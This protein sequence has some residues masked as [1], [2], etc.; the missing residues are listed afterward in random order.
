MTDQET[1]AVY[2]GLVHNDIDLISQFPLVW[3][4]S[5]CLGPGR[6]GGVAYKLRGL[7]LLDFTVHGSGV[8]SVHGSGVLL[9]FE[10]QDQ[11]L[12]F[13]SDGMCSGFHSAIVE[14]ASL[15]ATCSWCSGLLAERETGCGACRT[16]HMTKGVARCFVCRGLMEECHGGRK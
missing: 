1:Q 16:M 5:G 3:W 9:C 2:M 7:Q 13:H 4:L 14:V 8:C 15:A 12:M 10:E 11:G 6:E